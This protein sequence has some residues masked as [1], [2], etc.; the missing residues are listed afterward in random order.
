MDK[1]WGVGH[2]FTPFHVL[3]PRCFTMTTSNTLNAD[4]TALD[5]PRFGLGEWL[6]LD[7]YPNM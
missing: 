2:M 3:G 7:L 4:T 5:Y 1:V 6:V